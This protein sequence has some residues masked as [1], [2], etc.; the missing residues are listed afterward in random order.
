MSNNNN[1]NY[2]ERDSNISGSS[3]EGELFDNNNEDNYTQNNNIYL[4][5]RRDSNISGSS[6]EYDEYYNE[7]ENINIINEIKEI[8]SKNIEIGSLNTNSFN[9]FILLIRNYVNY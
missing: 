7:N 4:N 9:V 5:S 6:G 8:T 3:N 1:Y 2:N